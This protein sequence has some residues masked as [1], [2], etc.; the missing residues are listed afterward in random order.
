VIF[1]YLILRKVEEESGS[2]IPR[3]WTSKTDVKGMRERGGK[4]INVRKLV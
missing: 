1:N 3:G 4:G 2:V